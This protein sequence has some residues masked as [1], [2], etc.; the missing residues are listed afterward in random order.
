MNNSEIITQLR[1]PLDVDEIDFRIQSISEK[2]FATILAYKDARV[3]MNTLDNVCGAFWQTKYELIDGQLFC[4][5]G[6]KFGDEWVWRQDVGI[7]SNT[8]KEKG[9]ASDAF[10]RAG[11]RW[12]IGRELY[13]YPRIQLMLRSDEFRAKGNKAKQTYNLR[14]DKWVWKI[15]RDDS[16]K[17]I[18]L[19]GA[20][21]KGNLRFDSNKDFNGAPKMQNKPANVPNGKKQSTAANTKKWLNVMDK[22]GKNYTREWLNL[23]D[24][25][26]N[27]RIDSISQVK[28][29]YRVSQTTEKKINELIS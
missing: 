2:G 24:A 9:R 15:I 1:K 27:A 28:E 14:L 29:K 10:K 21:E 20:D 3:D 17:M 23:I 12:G 13:D 26:N 6:I 18:Q 19:T 8:E 22:S 25:V 7:E 5:I 16:G 11:F 4:S